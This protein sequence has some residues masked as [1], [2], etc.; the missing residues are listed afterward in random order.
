VGLAVDILAGTRRRA[1][2][3]L[4]NLGLEWLYRLCHEPLRLWRRYLVYNSIFLYRLLVETLE[5][6][7]RSDT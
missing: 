1:P 4:R 6:L 7:K 3:F 5:P 2:Q